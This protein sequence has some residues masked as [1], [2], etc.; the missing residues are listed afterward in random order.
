VKVGGKTLLSSRSR[1]RA[2]ILNPQIPRK[3]LFSFALRL[4][5]TPPFRGAGRTGRGKIVMTVD[6]YYGRVLVNA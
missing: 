1:A 6:P 3:S 4:S 5:L 2:L